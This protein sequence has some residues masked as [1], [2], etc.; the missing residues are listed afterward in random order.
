MQMYLFSLLLTVKVFTFACSSFP[1]E[2]ANQQ[3]RKPVVLQRELVLL[4]SLHGAG[5]RESG[6]EM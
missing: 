2:T 6:K 1:T 5:A 4:L 3:W